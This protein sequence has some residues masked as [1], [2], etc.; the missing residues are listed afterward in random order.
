MPM[1]HSIYDSDTHYSIDP[2]TRKLKNESSL[3]TTLIQGDH[4][5]ERFTFEIP[6]YIEGHDM[7]L[8]DKVEIHYVNTDAKTKW[9][10]NDVYEVTD[11]QV[12]SEDDQ[13]VIFSWLISGNATQ[14]AGGLSF[15]IKFKCFDDQ[16]NTKIAYTWSTAIYTGMSVTEG[17]NNSEG[18]VIDNS[19]TLEEWKQELLGIKDSIEGIERLIDE[20]GVLG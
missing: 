4:N 16:D 20:S 11:L 1:K 13:L 18:I 15:L 14:Y 17:M 8:C 12:Y 2:I 6:R 19:D 9:T 5:S 10:Y 7:S 3:K